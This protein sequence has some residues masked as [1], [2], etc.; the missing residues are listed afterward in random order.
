ML[1]LCQPEKSAGAGCTYSL[2]YCKNKGQFHTCGPKPGDQIFFGTSLDNSS[3]TGLVEKADGS[4]VYTIE[5]NS[6]D[7]VIR[8]I[9]ALSNSRILGCRRPAYDEAAGDTTLEQTPMLPFFLLYGE[10]IPMW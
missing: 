6:S 10:V 9:Y 5:G 1:L 4:K 8:R 2:R 3:H 7:Q